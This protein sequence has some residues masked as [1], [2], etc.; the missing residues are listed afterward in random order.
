MR[1]LQ[2]RLTKLKVVPAGTV[3]NFR[4]LHLNPLEVGGS[5]ACTVAASPPSRRVYVLQLLRLQFITP[6]QHIYIISFAAFLN[7]HS[8]I[9]PSLHANMS[10]ENQQTMLE[11]V[12]TDM[13]VNNMV[14][15]GLRQQ[16]QIDGRPVSSRPLSNFALVASNDTEHFTEMNNKD[17]ITFIAGKEDSPHGIRK[18]VASRPHVV[19]LS[20]RFKEL[21]DR[22]TGTIRRPF[23]C[24]KVTKPISLSTEDALAFRL[25]LCIAHLQYEKLPLR[26]DFIDI[27]RLTE[28]AER[29]ELHS[30]LLVHL[31][32][33]LR[34]YYQ[35]LFVP[36]FEQWLYI[37]HQ[38]NFDK[39]TLK[40]ASHLAM[41]CS[42]N[43]QGRLLM[44]NSDRP[45]DGRFPPGMLSMAPPC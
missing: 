39:I 33:W 4:M 40:L 23:R 36:G 31:E 29:F 26:L 24:H 14:Q 9:R 34:P 13:N 30:I 37:S 3:C 11:A 16:A 18:F 44:K 6:E 8:L 25:V 7:H 10:P 1:L 20:T 43:N 27:V 45:I 41:N 17:T 12:Q 35:K 19:A 32:S 5:S 22:H 21:V 38:F 15:D 42:I 28:A 2:Y